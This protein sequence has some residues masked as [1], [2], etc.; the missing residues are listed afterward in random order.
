MQNSVCRNADENA[1]KY[2]QLS[3]VKKK[4]FLKHARIRIL[5]SYLLLNLLLQFTFL[6]Q[7]HLLMIDFHKS[8]KNVALKEAEAVATSSASKTSII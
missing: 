2:F 4:V 7:S 3:E 1:R 8:S 5:Y 6:S